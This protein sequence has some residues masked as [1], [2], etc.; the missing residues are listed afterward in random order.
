MSTTQMSSRQIYLIQ[1]PVRIYIW[2]GNDVHPFQRKASLRILHSFSRHILEESLTYRPGYHSKD[3]QQHVLSIRLRIE[4]QGYE[5]RNLQSLMGKMNEVP[6]RDSRI[7][8]L[9]LRLPKLSEQEDEEEAK[10]NVGA[11]EDEGMNMGLMRALTSV[12]HVPRSNQLERRHSS[13]A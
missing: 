8:Y 9:M 5:S 6:G 12:S 3:M 1:T 4:T 13:G 2:L 7:D 10:E 11:D